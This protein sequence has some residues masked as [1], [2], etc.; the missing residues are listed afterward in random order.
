MGEQVLSIPVPVTYSP[1]PPTRRRTRAKP[2]QNQPPH[3]PSSIPDHL[4]ALS[5][6]DFLN[7][8]SQ[9]RRTQPCQQ[10]KNEW[11]KMD[12]GDFFDLNLYEDSSSA[13]ITPISE[14]AAVQHAEDAEMH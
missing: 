7:H 9:L 5:K 11:K 2:V 1:P 10:E 14:T 3:L 4:Q 6:L 12:V 8:E 13:T